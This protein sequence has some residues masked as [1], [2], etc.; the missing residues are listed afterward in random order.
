MNKSLSL[1]VGALFALSSVT[2]F[3]AKHM[4]G[5]KDD[6]KPTAAECK[7]DPKMKGCEDM[8]KK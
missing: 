6:K 4:A 1:L 2:G 7:K 5:E 8:K 3:A